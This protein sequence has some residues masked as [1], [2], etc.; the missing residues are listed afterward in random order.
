M[1][2]IDGLSAS[3]SEIVAGAIQDA[4][5]GMLVGEKSFGKGS[6]QTIFKLSDGGALKVTTA[7]YLTPQ[8]VSYTH[9]D[10]YKRQY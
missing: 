9:L 7:K 6:V 4:S 2:L 10:V 8:A 3:A 5:V 1:V